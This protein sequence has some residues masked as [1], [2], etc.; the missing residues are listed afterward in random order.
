MALSR[1]LKWLVLGLGGLA[2]VVVLA[3]LLLPYL[4][5]LQRYGPVVSAQVQQ[6]TGRSM[7]LG[8]ITFRLL[9]T[10]AL[11]VAP[12]ALA[13]GPAYPGRDALRVDSLSM[14]M[15]L[16]PLLRGRIEFGTIVIDRPVF[17]L[18]R[19]RQGRWN[20][21][22]V[23][24]RFTG[25]PGAGAAGAAGGA[26]P[27]AGPALAIARAEIRGGRILLYDDAVVPGKRSELQ[28]GP[29]DATLTGW[30]G[31]GATN[32]DLSVGLGGSRLRATAT[33]AGGQGPSVLDAGVARS[34]LE[35]AD[36]VTLLP[37]LGVANPRGL[38]VT[39]AVD[40]EGKAHVP[41]E[42]M[43][44]IAFDGALTVEGVSYRDATMSRPLEKL[45]GRLEIHGQR[46]EWKD[47]TATLGASEVRGRLQVEDFLRP[48]IGFE[49]DCPRIDL[50]DLI[51]AFSTA[52]AA[53]AP[54]AAR[55][56]AGGDG[57]LAVSARGTVKVDALRFM[58]FDLADVRGTVT[59]KD[60]LLTVSDLGAKLYDGALKGGATLSLAG[61]TPAYSVNAALEGVDVNALAAA[62]DAG[63]KDLLKGRLGGRL[64]VTASGAALDAM[65]G[66]A[67]GTARL[68]IAKGA[69]A[70]FSILK[71]LASLLEMAG[72]KGIGR[73]ETPFDLLSGTF[74][75]SDRRARTSDLALDSADLDLAGKGD[76]GLDATLAL[77]IAATF[78]DEASRGMV[79]K[80]PRLKA[81]T[82]QNGRIVVHLTAGGS[83]AQ[84][85]I[86][87]DTRAQTKQLGEQK[88]EEAKEKLRG[89]LLDLLGGKPKK[90]EPPPPP[91]QR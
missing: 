50:N 14:R 70:S 54:A 11:T 53:G 85:Q 4:V 78:S 32:L 84:P 2:A 75:I 38:K 89:K 9:P 86:G 45:G 24:A 67:R 59:L 91:P 55:Q 8:R 41:L 58:T 19:D 13:D 87:L 3:A 56:E 30:G 88:K 33:L 49:L 20:Y 15:R 61:R 36:F 76:V 63:L 22:D 65:L 46:A 23:L 5:D 82:D 35:A 68:E 43:E 31:G 29:V 37:W 77:A 51:A 10:P 42:K 60:A 81:L 39:G 18:I 28:V 73:D 62:Y 7:T 52:P 90:E 17:T 1:P 69:L 71:Q 34:R 6:L 74:D 57:L 16:L 26:T 12:V 47:F 83:L 79:E 27:T 66:S 44:A 40:I 21:D 48:R 64:A 72:G 80:T 25:A